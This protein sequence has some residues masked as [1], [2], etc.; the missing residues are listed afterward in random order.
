M[1]IVIKKVSELQPA[2]YNPRIELPEDDPRYRKLKRSIERFGLVEPLLWN[3]RTSH[4]IGGHQRLRILK[5]LDF[6]EVP[7]ALLDLPLD[8]EMALNIILNNREAQ[9][10]WDLPQ[11]TKVLEELAALPEP[12]LSFTGFDPSHLK[13]LQSELTPNEIP[14]EVEEPSQFYEI[15]LR[16][17]LAQ[18][19]EVRPDLDTLIN[20][21]D[22]ET[23]VRHR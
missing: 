3:Q 21:Y 13:T 17:P 6:D 9:G 4:L 22:L 5:S 20:C 12:Q 2:P 18:L 1:Q 23:H 14:M 15:M 7:V 11:L 8:Q 19:P 10:D 16:I